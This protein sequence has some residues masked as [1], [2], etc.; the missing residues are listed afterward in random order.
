MPDTLECYKILEIEP[1]S[2]AERVRNAYIAL[3]RT[4]DPER[5]VNNPLLRA[6][7]EKKR[8]EIDEA[9]NAIRF[10]LP[11]LQDPDIES[12]KMRRPH[13]DFKELATGNEPLSTKTVISVLFVVLVG[14]V[15]YSAYYLYQRGLRFTPSPT[16][17]SSVSLEQ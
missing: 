3:A 2:S 7:A 9:F 10:F 6:Q 16:P 17:A 15:A 12:K 5:Y 1:G 13:R 14:I 11:E 8:K 4:W